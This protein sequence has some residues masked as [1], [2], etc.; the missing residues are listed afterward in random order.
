MFYP[1]RNIIKAES[2]LALGS[3]PQV[4]KANRIQSLPSHPAFQRNTIEVDPN[5]SPGKN[6]GY[7]NMASAAGSALGDNLNN[8]NAN[9]FD[10]T[11][12][13]QINQGIDA[14][15]NLPIIGGF[16]KGAEGI[17]SSVRGDG[18]NGLR[19][20]FGDTLGGANTIKSIASGRYKEAIP[21]YG[22]FAKARRIKGQMKQE[23]TRL[24]QYQSRN[25]QAQSNAQFGQL[26]FANGGQI[27]P[28]NK[29]KDQNKTKPLDESRRHAP[30]KQT[31]VNINK[32]SDFKGVFS[33]D[34][35]TEQTFNHAFRRARNNGD[36]DF[37]WQG[38]RYSSDLV[39]KETDESYK[40]AKKYI[41]N[42]ISNSDKIGVSSLDSAIYQNNPE[43]I[44]AQNFQDRKMGQE[45]LNRPS[46]FTI[47]NQ[48]KKNDARIGVTEGTTTGAFNPIDHSVYITHDKNNKYVSAHELTHK[49]GLESHLTPNDQKD[50]AKYF[51]MYEDGS[52]KKDTDMRD[53]FYFDYISSPPER[54]ARHMVTR[55]YLQDNGFDSNKPFGKKEIEFI[56]KQG[57]KLPQEI[58]DLV[59]IYDDN[60]F[61]QQMNDKRE[62]IKKY[63]D[64]GKI[65]SAVILGGKGHDEGG[66]DV[67]DSRTKQKVAETESH[68]L[69]LTKS[70]TETVE[71]CIEL[72]D[73]D[74]DERHLLRLG[75]EIT[76]IITKFTKDNSGDYDLSKK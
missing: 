34:Y 57:N 56:K 46:Y 21:I 68:E 42:Y 2:G 14:V 18:T 71:K 10:D 59:S 6:L 41:S 3:L 54:A 35:S 53:I 50:M 73:K 75:K 8:P 40:S 74:K 70:Q 31:S 37:V 39:N 63:Q 67:I 29:K 62:S 66:N 52:R 43:Y 72:Y 30:I 22:G 64:G 7:A 25:A 61:I 51:M 32:V 45:Q 5:K 26:T 1:K 15:K 11:K 60:R 24:K 47:T 13:Q 55:K 20:S 28:K 4:P 65:D 44:K 12:G 49:A 23:E 16:A 76:E 38:N 9:R 69:L 48:P 58:K 33:N 19:N 36:K 27:D 17:S